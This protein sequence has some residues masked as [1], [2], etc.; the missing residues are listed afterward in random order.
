MVTFHR[1]WKGIAGAIGWSVAAGLALWYFVLNRQ[2]GLLILWIMF[3]CAL[4]ILKDG[5]P[6]V[7]QNGKLQLATL[8]LPRTIRPN[9]SKHIS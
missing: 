5:L 4:F 9:S 2:G 8:R 6:V 7:R 1:W 3:V